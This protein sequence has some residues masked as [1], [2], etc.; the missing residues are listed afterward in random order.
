[1]RWKN[2]DFDDSHWNTP[3]SLSGHT[4][5]LQV[6]VPLATIAGPASSSIVMLP[7][8]ANGTLVLYA[9]VILLHFCM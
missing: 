8:I 4:F 9:L 5:P 1:M 3:T 7:Q 6:P 2:V